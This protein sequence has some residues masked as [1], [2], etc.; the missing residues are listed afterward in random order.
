[1]SKQN[2]SQITSG[3]K[4]V[5]FARTVSMSQCTPEIE[6]QLQDC[7]K[8]AKSHGLEVVKEFTSI[9]GAGREQFDVL[10][11]QLRLSNWGAIVVEDRPTV[12]TPARSQP[13]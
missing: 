5:I 8:Y 3:K 13:G 9:G 1:M 12:S 11:R 4:A 10:V 2:K 7:R 6:V